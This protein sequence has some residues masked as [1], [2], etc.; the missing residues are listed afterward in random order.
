MEP[1][2]TIATADPWLVALLHS[3]ADAK[4]SA[5]AITDSEAS[6][7]REQAI[8][9][10]A[11]QRA[12]GIEPQPLPWFD[13][14]RYQFS[15]GDTLL[16]WCQRKLFRLLGRES[17]ALWQDSSDLHPPRNLKRFAKSSLIPGGWRVVYALKGQP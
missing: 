12:Q 3:L 10:E 9:I 2:F 11:G 15:A 17:G 4:Q 7:L 8:A 1:V 13:H 16:H 14:V 5:G 6:D